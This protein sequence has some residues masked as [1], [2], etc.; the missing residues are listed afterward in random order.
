MPATIQ[1]WSPLKQL[2]ASHGNDTEKSF[3][4]AHMPYYN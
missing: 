4:D 3:L 1:S 2:T